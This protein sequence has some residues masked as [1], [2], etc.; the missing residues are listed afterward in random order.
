MKKKLIAVFLVLS[1]VFL[2]AATN[3][4]DNITVRDTS[5]L[6]GITRMLTNGINGV[7]V[8]I[9]TNGQ[10]GIGQNV[11]PSNGFL[12]DMH[13]FQDGQTKI[14]LSNTNTGTSVSSIM[15]IR[16]DAPGGI[17]I[18][19]VGQ[20]F[21]GSTPG[22]TA[23]IYS[24]LDIENFMFLT[25]RAGTPFFFRTS[26]GE[27]FRISD[28]AGVLVT[29][30]DFKVTGN[31]VLVSNLT[32]GA[33]SVS[34]FTING[35]TVTAPNTLNF[36]ANTMWITNGGVAFGTNDISTLETVRIQ[37]GATNQVALVVRGVPGGAAIDTFDIRNGGGSLMTAF[38]S[39]GNI[40]VLGG[41]A[42]SIT[43]SGGFMGLNNGGKIQFGNSSGATAS[44]AELNGGTGISNSLFFAASGVQIASMTTNA[45]LFNRPVVIGTNG[46]AIDAVLIKKVT[47]DAPSISTDTTFTTNIVLAGSLTNSGV[48]PIIGVSPTAGIVYQANVPSNGFCN[49]MMIN[50][51]AGSIDPAAQ[52][53]GVQVN[54]NTIAISP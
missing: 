40:R 6:N 20:N 37:A 47:F 38:T 12:V 44:S 54:N 30:T 46:M 39:N 22:S 10:L 9:W 5:R 41:T 23:E 17:V 16:A 32:I 34:T 4:F 2:L 26:T 14:R 50:S 28:A 33:S 18:G 25:Q 11:N 13:Q 19:V 35:T 42:V 49:I 31:S 43:G 15:Q 7:T 53:V 8:G 48:V 24:E 1:A 51:T 45:I 52:T 3:S 36:N 29:N 27:K 21:A